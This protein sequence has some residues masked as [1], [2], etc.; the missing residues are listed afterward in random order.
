MARE[1]SLFAELKRRNVFRAAAVYAAMAWLLMQ[2]V[3][4][5][6]PVYGLPTWS[7]RWIIGALAIGFPFWLLFAWYYELTPGGIKRESEVEPRES[8]ARQTGRRLDFWIIGILAV[9]VVLLLTDRLVTHREAAAVMDKSVAV[10]P[11]ANTSGDPGNEYFSDGLSE[12]LINTLGRVPDL[13][14]IGRTSSFAFKGK[15]GDTRRSA[16]SS[17]WPTCWKAACARRTIAC[18]SRWN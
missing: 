6:F 11:F 15:T 13:K 16:T 10:L 9:C 3:T 17:A 4:Q 7:M 1:R 2:V 12:Q 14:V 18:A 8:I 5:L